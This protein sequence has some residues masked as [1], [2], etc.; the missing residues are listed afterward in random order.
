[1]DHHNFHGKDIPHIKLDPKMKIEDLVEVYARS[2]Y[3]ARKLGE[4]AKLYS[5]MINEDAIICLTVSGAM[6]PVGIGGIIQTLIE[7]G[8]FCMGISCKTRTL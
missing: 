3:N 1:V 4:A 8:S 5:K 2:G 6:T 7:R